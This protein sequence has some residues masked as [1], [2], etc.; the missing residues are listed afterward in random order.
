ME[1]KWIENI[2]PYVFVSQTQANDVE[3]DTLMKIP[4]NN[5]QNGNPSKYKRF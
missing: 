4:L 2:S 1:G 3:F 5:F